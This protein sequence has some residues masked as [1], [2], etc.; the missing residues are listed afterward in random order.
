MATTFT[1]ISLGNL[2][3]IDTTEG[4]NLAENAAALEGLVFGGPG[5]A[6]LL[7]AVTFSPGSTGF[8]GGTSTAYDQDNIPAETFR[9]NGGPEQT[10][11]SSV[12]YNATITYS[13][14]T[15]AS[16]TA[17]I[18]QDTLGNTYW[19]PEF[20]PN[21]DQIALQAGP[22]QS[23]TLD[24]LQTAIFSGLT[25]DR[26]IWDVVPCFVEG[27][28]IATNHGLRA[29]EDV[30][31][32]DKVETRDHGLQ[33][34]RWIGSS[35]VTGVGKLA[36]VRISAGALGEN[37]PVRDLR[38]SR[39][40]RMLLG[41]KV[42][43]RLFGSAEVLVPAIKLTKLPG[44]FIEEGDAPVKYYHLVT[45]AHEIIFA[46]GA[47]SE[48]LLCGPQALHAL[49]QEAI[50]E[51]QAIFPNLLETTL[52]PARPIQ[53]DKRIEQLL[54]RHTKHGIPHTSGQILRSAI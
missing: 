20:S 29:I 51:L 1:V 31:I 54:M 37:C 39:Q 2:A 16:I 38:V 9:I 22:I 26:Q 33:V 24:S 5:D 10:F 45:D 52:V 30:Q 47:P 6:L 11:D 42:C 12:T 13:D 46:E 25:G 44:V 23:L 28:R 19:A 40:H 43:E 21:A 32:G 8:A 4:N 18:F 15:T 41:S 49:G 34:V 36:P 17:V 14:G 50:E 27:T 7:N 53:Q 48:T 3:D 35:T